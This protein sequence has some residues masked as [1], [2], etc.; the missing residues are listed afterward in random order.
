MRAA[1]NTSLAYKKFDGGSQT[2][3]NRVVLDT[4]G[5][6]RD[7]A[8]PKAID[9]NSDYLPLM[10]IRGSGLYFHAIAASS[11]SLERLASADNN[12][13]DGQLSTGELA[14]FIDRWQANNPADGALYEEVRYAVHWH[15]KGVMPTSGAMIDLNETDLGNALKLS[16]PD[17]G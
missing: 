14:A 8:F 6:C 2:W 7:P 11:V 13:A 3:G 10:W 4:G 16:A 9:M 1:D 15:L 17:G 12:P 5:E